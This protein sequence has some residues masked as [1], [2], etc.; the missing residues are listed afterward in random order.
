MEIKR[1]K[2]FVIGIRALMV[3]LIALFVASSSFAAATN[4]GSGT[5]KREGSGSKPIWSGYPPLGPLSQ[6]KLN[7]EEIEL[8]RLLFFDNRYSGDASDS[9]A[10]CHTPEKGYGD[11]K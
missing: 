1:S 8:G 7:K 11:G 5:K 9:C 4:E 10:T 3:I 2:K 6:E